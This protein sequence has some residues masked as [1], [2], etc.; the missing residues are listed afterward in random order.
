M[1]RARSF[2]RSVSAAAS[3][4]CASITH[5]QPHMG[6]CCAPPHSGQN[7][8]P[9]GHG[10]AAVDAEFRGGV[11][12]GGTG[13]PAGARGGWSSGEP[14]GPG[15]IAFIML[16]AIVSPAPRPTP[17]PA[18]PPPS[19]AGRDGHRLRHLELRVAAHVAHHV[20]A[21][22]LVEPFLQLIRQRKI[23][24]HEGIERQTEIGEHRLQRFRDLLRRAR[25]GW[26]PYRETERCFRRTCPTCGR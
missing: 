21:D 7:F 6:Y 26:R 8:A 13:G 2:A 16:C 9:R 19:F 4:P 10:L 17:M 18:A 15:F 1:K 24:D 22:A 11:A 20:H 12:A 25:S 5:S 23:F 14:P 3:Q